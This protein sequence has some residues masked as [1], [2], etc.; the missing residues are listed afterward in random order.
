[1]VR[2]GGGVSRGSVV[3]DK[4]CGHRPPARKLW[5]AVDLTTADK[6]T[7]PDLLTLRQGDNSLAAISTQTLPHH[8]IP[9][10]CIPAAHTG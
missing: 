10:H 9:A 8:C 5:Y 4:C 2:D 6:N 1:M 7:K 3:C